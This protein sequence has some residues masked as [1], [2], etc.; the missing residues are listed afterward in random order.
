[1]SGESNLERPGVSSRIVDGDFVYQGP[2]IFSGIAL[3]GMKLLGM[4][5]AFEIEPELVVES[6][7]V[8]YQ[9]VAVPASDGVPV[10]GRVRIGGM[11]APVH[12]D[13]PVAVDVA[14]EQEKDVSRSLNDPPGI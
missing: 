5:M 1:M 2:E 4:R 13:L 12:E 3:D 14:L 10:P 7:C 9:R 8:D 11:L 6:H